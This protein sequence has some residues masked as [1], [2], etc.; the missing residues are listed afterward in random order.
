VENFDTWS[1]KKKKNLRDSTSKVGESAYLWLV[2]EENSDSK[3]LGSEILLLRLSWDMEYPL[4]R[5]CWERVNPFTRFCST[6]SAQGL[7]LL[8][9]FICFRVPP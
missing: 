7:V 8:L 9:L 6:S 4:A 2:S 1:K 5:F 3:D